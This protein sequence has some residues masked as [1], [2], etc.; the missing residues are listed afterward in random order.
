MFVGFGFG[1]FFAVTVWVLRLLL[2][3]FFPTYIY[4]A[5]SC[6]IYYHYS[7][8]FQYVVGTHAFSCFVHVGE[9]GRP[10]D[11]R[12]TFLTVAGCFGQTNVSTSKKTD[13]NDR[14]TRSGAQSLPVRAKRR[15]QH[16][17]C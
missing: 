2:L 15:A 8:A 10:R 14:R 12:N 5:H 13:D 11:R 16:Y 7:L 1:F 17:C 4:R 6:A 3:Y 9:S